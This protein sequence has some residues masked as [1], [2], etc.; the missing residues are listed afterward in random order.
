MTNPIFS[1]D[2]GHFWDE[3][4]AKNTQLFSEADRLDEKAYKIIELGID[5][6]N[7]WTR[8]MEA[9]ASADAKRSEAYSDWMRIKREM[10]S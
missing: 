9:K 3:Q 4:I 8:F 10:I 5:E 7:V 1:I 2:D 6:P